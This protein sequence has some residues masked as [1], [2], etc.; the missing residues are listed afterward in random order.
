MPIILREP[1]DKFCILSSQA[2]ASNPLD[3]SEMCETPTESYI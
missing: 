1:E 2:S 3:P